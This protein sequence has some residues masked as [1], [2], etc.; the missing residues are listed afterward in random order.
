MLSLFLLQ[1]FQP[2]IK[3]WPLHLA[4]WWILFPAT[5]FS[6][7]HLSWL[8]NQILPFNLMPIVALGTLLF[9]DLISFLSISITDWDLFMSS[10]FTSQPSLLETR[11]SERTYFRLLLQRSTF[12][13]CELFTPIVLL[14]LGLE[15]FS[16]I[17]W[18]KDDSSSNRGLLFC[19]FLLLPY[20]KSSSDVT[21]AILS[22]LCSKIYF[23]WCIP[24]S[25]SQNLLSMVN[26]S[27]N[28]SMRPSL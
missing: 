14:T 18:L 1:Q 21:M 25:N 28:V 11:P 10:P 2:V 5:Q 7:F 16:I 15:I 26:W 19:L 6:S 24:T 27:L 3:S 9:N 22:C 20:S 23:I 4:Y 13:V 8:Q 17:L 12:I